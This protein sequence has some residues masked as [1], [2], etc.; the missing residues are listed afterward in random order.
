MKR[1]SSAIT[2]GDDDN[3]GQESTV[4][5]V[6]KRVRQLEIINSNTILSHKFE[7]STIPEEFLKMFASKM[8]P[9]LNRRKD[10]VPAA[11]SDTPYFHI[12]NG[13]LPNNNWTKEFGDFYLN[14]CK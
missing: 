10:A 8:I 3:D 4:F 12:Q 5:D 14:N 2:G 6:R 13:L 11:R 1:S 7:I 9:T